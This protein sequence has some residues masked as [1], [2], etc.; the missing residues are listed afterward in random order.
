[1]NTELKR[2]ISYAQSLIEDRQLHPAIEVYRRL[3]NKFPNQPQVLY[4]LG[5]AFQLVSDFYQASE[6]FKKA[7]KWLS[8]STNQY[9]VILIEWSFSLNEIDR[10]EEAL[11]KIRQALKVD[12]NNS[13]AWFTQAEIFFNL[14]RYKDAVISAKKSLKLQKTVGAYHRLSK[15]FHELH[16]FENAIKAGSLAVDYL[17]VDTFVKDPE[18]IKADYSLKLLLNG[19]FGLGWK[20][21][22]HRRNIINAKVLKINIPDLDMFPPNVD[23]VLIYGEQGVGDQIFFASY[24]NQFIHQTTAKVTIAC[25][26]R[27]IPV[28]IRSFADAKVINIGLLSTENFVEKHDFHAAIPIGSLPRL[29][30]DSNR[31]FK[32][33]S[34]YLNADASRVAYWRAWLDRNSPDL[35]VGI[36]WRGGNIDSERKKRSIALSMFSELCIEGVQLYNLQYGNYDEEI[37]AFNCNSAIKLSVIDGVDSLQELDNFCGLVKSLDLVISVDNT[38]V[39]VAGALG[40][41]CWVLLPSIPNFRWQVK[42]SD[43][44]WYPETILYRQEKDANWN[45]VVHSVKRD[46]VKLL[47]RRRVNE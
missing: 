26:E 19:D 25:E 32:N 38:T 21:Y 14:G 30:F 13:W 12:S 41:P 27:L 34:A 44:D 31:G 46:L 24:L 29:M 42:R 36:S 43:T 8:K 28:F 37:H 33:Q 10:S 15:A 3:D 45:T 5:K 6:S 4:N 22:E 7:A 23:K 2:Q 40:V 20:L 39:H 11:I 17:S 9:A 1:M 16:Q 35:K 18:D 47:E